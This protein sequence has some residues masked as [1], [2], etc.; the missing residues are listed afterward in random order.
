MGRLILK[1]VRRSIV[2]LR[3]RSCDTRNGRKR[4]EKLE[5]WA[6]EDFVDKS[7]SSRLRSTFGR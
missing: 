4:N 3:S 6:L 7:L 1:R 2:S 5:R